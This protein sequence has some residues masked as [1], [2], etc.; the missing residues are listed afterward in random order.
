MM[1]SIVT[2]GMTREQL[3]SRLASIP[4]LDAEDLA[5]I[6]SNADLLSDEQAAGLAE[7]ADATGYGKRQKFVRIG[8]GAAIGLTVGV[9][10]GKLVL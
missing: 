10:V 3:K 2:A 8:I 1:G 7:V 9:I 6:V 5:V 4:P